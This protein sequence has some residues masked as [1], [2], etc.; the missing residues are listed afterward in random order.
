ME[1]AKEI[2][3]KFP[4][5]KELNKSFDIKFP[6]KILLWKFMLGKKSNPNT[7]PQ[8]IDDAANFE[9]TFLLKKP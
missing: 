3:N 1:I 4:V 9:L 8:M 5:I 2:N 7:R 6:T